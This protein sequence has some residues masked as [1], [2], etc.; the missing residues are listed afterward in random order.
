MK[1]HE[2]KMMVFFQFL[3]TNFSEFLASIDSFRNYDYLSQKR[4][5]AQTSKKRGQCQYLVIS[6]NKNKNVMDIVALQ[7]SNLMS[8]LDIDKDQQGQKGTFLTLIKS[9]TGKFYEILMKSLCS[10]S[11]NVPVR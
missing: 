8:K 5:T 6:D 4:L 2:I 1:C 3:F 11:V 10:Y 9:S 7:I